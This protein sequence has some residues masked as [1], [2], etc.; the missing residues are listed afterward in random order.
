M[1]ETDFGARNVHTRSRRRATKIESFLVLAKIFC[2]F[3]CSPAR[4]TADPQWLVTLN[5]T[6][7][8]RHQTRIS[9]NTSV[10]TSTV[11]VP[12][13]HTEPSSHSLFGVLH[14][15]ARSRAYLTCIFI[16]ISG[17]HFLVFHFEFCSLFFPL[18]IRVDCLIQPQVPLILLQKHK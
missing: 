12:V 11:P 4:P 17:S 9:W 16:L 5:G 3:S 14:T 15:L 1:I 6:T 7:A 13:V 2:V 8:R 18:S 10:D